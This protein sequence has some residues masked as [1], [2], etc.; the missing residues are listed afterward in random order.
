MAKYDAGAFACL[1]GP[2][3]LG[4]HLSARTARSGA[5][6]ASRL[7]LALLCVVNPMTLE[8]ISIGHPEEPLAAALVAGAVLAAAGRRARGRRRCWES[9][10]PPSSGRWWRRRWCW[11]PH[12]GGALALVA[13][14]VATAAV[15]LVPATLADRAAADA[16][17]DAILDS[18]LASL[19]SAWWPLSSDLPG[20]AS[21]RSLPSGD[22]PD[23]DRARA[24]RPGSADWR[25]AC[26]GANGRVGA[27]HALALLALVLLLRCALDPSALQY[28]TVAPMLAMCAWEAVARPGLPLISLLYAASSWVVFGPLLDTQQDTLINASYLT[29]T[30][31]FAVL[32]AR[33]AFA[34]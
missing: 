19:L 21:A 24:V 17:R 8:A 15:F 18:R 22:H 34:R 3:A 4:V 7:V 5:G 23:G 25:R 2:V 13:I 29:L 33:A 20:G 27:E 9:P 26:G 1:L 32:M 16:V 31:L 14:A 28:Y 12:A 11:W 10:W 30:A 6:L